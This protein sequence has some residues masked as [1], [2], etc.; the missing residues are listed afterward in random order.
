MQPLPR[1]TSFLAEIG[2]FT[3]TLLAG[4]I[5]SLVTLWLA[6]RQRTNQEKQAEPRRREAFLAAIGR[7]L[8]WNR[9]ATRET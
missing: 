9:V 2:A 6:G 1:P 4:V 5:V 3:L 8:R 7:E